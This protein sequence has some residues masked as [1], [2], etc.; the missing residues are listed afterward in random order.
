MN[1][2]KL[3][4]CHR[5][6]FCGRIE[7]HGA[8]AER[9]H[10]AIQSNV[11]LLQFAQVS[12]HLGFAA[13]AMEHLM[14]EIGGRSPQLVRNPHRDFSR[15]TVDKERLDHSTDHGLISRLI[16][17]NANG[18]LI[19][20]AQIESPVLGCGNNLLG[21]GWDAHG[22]GVEPGVVD[23]LDAPRP[24]PA[25][26]LRGEP[27]HPF[28]N[29]TQALG[30]MPHG[31]Q[32]GHHRQQRLCSADVRSRLLA[33]DVLLASGQGQ[34][35]GHPTLG[36]LR[37]PNQA[38]REGP[39]VGVPG[40]NERSVRP[41]VHHRNPEAL[42][43]SDCNVGTHLPR[44]REQRESEKIGGDGDHNARF[45]EIGDQL[46]PFADGAARS[47]I[48]QDDSKDL[49]WVDCGRIPDGDVD[50]EGPCP[51]LDYLDHLRVAIRIDEKGG[52]LSLRDPTQH[53]HGLRH[54]RCL[55]QQR[56]IGDVE[57]GEIANHCLEVEHCLETPLG[58]LW[59]IWRV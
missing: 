21:P 5:S 24:Q 28:G 49:F 20:K 33:S 8:R 29:R 23:H 53:R 35:Q 31:I 4:P 46:P 27:V 18:V 15:P 30:S 13:V 22:E 10:R 9:N 42:R 47:G 38:S 52:R 43:R 59:L 39:L 51:R 45:L 17:R 26:Q 1:V 40:R 48:L 16:E 36:V 37:Y 54:R 2:G 41:A 14:G 57:A 44:R 12:H 34:P 19:D 32:P 7:L 58:D 25:G 56:S 6:H 50:S 55:I 3:G 11:A